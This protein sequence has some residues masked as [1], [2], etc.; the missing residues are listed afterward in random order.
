MPVQQPICN[1]GFMLRCLIVDDNPR[2]LDA[3]RGLLW[4]EGV[5]VVGT[6]STSAEAAQRVDELRPDVA[7]V[8]ID[9]G[10][11]SGFDVARQLHGNVRD[12]PRIILISTHAG[13]DYADLIAASPAVGFLA[14]TAL[15]S[16]AIH[17]LLDGHGQD[18]T[19]KPVSG[20][21]GR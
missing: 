14:K 9:L 8:D 6:A 5:A 1:P 2:F 16:R 13:Q 12:A 11:D 19:G 3:A 15:S 10:G 20:P 17:Q 21:P 4:R 18:D 7:L